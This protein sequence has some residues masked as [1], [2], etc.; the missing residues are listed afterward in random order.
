MLRKSLALA[1]LV[2]GLAGN[3]TFS[4]EAL[5]SQLQACSWESTVKVKLYNESLNTLFSFLGSKGKVVINDVLSMPAFNVSILTH[6]NLCQLTTGLNSNL[7]L[8]ILLKQANPQKTLV[9]TKSQVKP[10]YRVELARDQKRVGLN[11]IIGKGR[12]LRG[13][14]GEVEELRDIGEL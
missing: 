6:S 9:L 4:S 7:S 1:I 3:L 12:G 14:I 5:S 2:V 8:L 11:H 10:E 13:I